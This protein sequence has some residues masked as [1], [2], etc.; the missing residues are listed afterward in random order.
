MNNFTFMKECYTCKFS[1]KDEEEYPCSICLGC[2]R[3]ESPD[4]LDDWLE[5][6]DSSSATKCYEAIDLLKKEIELK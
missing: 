1:H 2:N 3:W 6:F 5:S 4:W